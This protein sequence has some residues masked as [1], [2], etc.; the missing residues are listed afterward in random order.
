MLSFRAVVTA[1]VFTTGFVGPSAGASGSDLAFLDNIEQHGFDQ[2]ADLYPDIVYFHTSGNGCRTVRP[3]S[4]AA[5]I[6]SD[7]VEQVQ[8]GLC[9]LAEMMLEAQ[10]ADDSVVEARITVRQDHL[11]EIVRG[12]IEDDGRFR[13]LDWDIRINSQLPIANEDVLLS[14]DVVAISP[15]SEAALQALPPVGATPPLSN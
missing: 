13:E 5:L 12:V 9:S 7:P 15:G 3:S 4:Y 1:F 2:I 6:P 11:V 10:T 14:L 8:I